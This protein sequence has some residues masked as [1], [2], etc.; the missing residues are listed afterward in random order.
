MSDSKEKKTVAVFDFDGT[1]TTKDS[2]LEFV[3]YTCGPFALYWGLFLMSPL[4]VLMKLRLYPNWKVKEKF[5]GYYFR[6]WK[7]SDFKQKG[8]AFADVVDSFKRLEMVDILNT[9]LERGDDVCV[10]TASIQ[11]WVEPY[12]CRIGILHV[13]GTLVEVDDNGLLTGRLKSKNCY[14]QEKVERFL[15]MMPNRDKYILHAYGDSR[16]DREL[17]AYAD[18][19]HK[20]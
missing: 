2:L 13:A 19:A 16:G 11:E 15:K 10:V 9:Y 6:G 8:V 18:C 4:L 12:C 1:L 7:Y 20:L 17:L 5:F 14:G 3:K